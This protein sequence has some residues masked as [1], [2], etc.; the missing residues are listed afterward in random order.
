MSNGAKRLKD[1][2]DGRLREKKREQGNEENIV[3]T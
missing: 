3:E 2:K 1:R